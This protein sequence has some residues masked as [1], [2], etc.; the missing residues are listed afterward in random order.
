MVDDVLRGIEILV[1]AGREEVFGQENE[2]PDGDPGVCEIKASN[3]GICVLADKQGMRPCY[4][5][6]SCDRLFLSKMSVITSGLPANPC[7]KRR[8]FT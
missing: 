7:S 3:S 8:A 1:N 2:L 5:S 6:H 4:C